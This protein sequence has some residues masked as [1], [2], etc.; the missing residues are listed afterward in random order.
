M[1]DFIKPSSG[2]SLPALTFSEAVPAAMGAL[3]WAVMLFMSLF[4]HGVIVDSWYY[5]LYVFISVFFAC[6]LSAVTS[7]VYMAF[8][9]KANIKHFIMMNAGIPLIIIGLFIQF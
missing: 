8:A 1:S 9:M 5:H 3:P 2:R 4:L 7:L 6:C